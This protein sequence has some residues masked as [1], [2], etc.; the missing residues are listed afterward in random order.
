VSDRCDRPRL[1]PALGLAILACACAPLGSPE[2]PPVG[3]GGTPCSRA[4]AV[5]ASTVAVTAGICNPWCVVVGAGTRV[6]FLNQ[7]PV[8]YLFEA[9]G[10]A[11]FELPLPPMAGGATP[12]LPVGMVVVSA[13][14][15]P[16]TS[17]TVFVE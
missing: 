8:T 14:H 5:R 3:D 9:S 10:S 1:S 12:P 15:A 13:A 16:T 6:N 11:T 7:D 2:P 17:V 4:S